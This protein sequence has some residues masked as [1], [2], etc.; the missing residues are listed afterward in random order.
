MPF[1]AFLR[2]TKAF[3]TTQI[4]KFKALQIMAVFLHSLGQHRTVAQVKQEPLQ[5]KFNHRIA[6]RERA[7]P[8]SA[9]N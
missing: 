3:R 1:S 7:A 5:D 4:P 8:A 2:L 9:A 6:A